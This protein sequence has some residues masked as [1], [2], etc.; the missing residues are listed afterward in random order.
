[1]RKGLP[2][3]RGGSASEAAIMPYAFPSGSALVWR[4]LV[5]VNLVAQRGFAA[6]NRR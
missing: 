3:T 5:M 1:V 2:E 6:N 4:Q